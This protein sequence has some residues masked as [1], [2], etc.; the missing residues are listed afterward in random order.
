M[1]HY[2]EIFEGDIENWHKVKELIGLDYIESEY[3][4]IV[5]QRLL[6]EYIEFSEKEGKK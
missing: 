1:R 3:D 5:V 2:L 6:Q 4:A